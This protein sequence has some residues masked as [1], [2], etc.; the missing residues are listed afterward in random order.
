MTEIEDEEKIDPVEP[1]SDV[2]IDLGP[3]IDDDDGQ[4]DEYQLSSSPNDFNVLTITSFIESGAIKIPGFQR[5]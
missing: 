4:I 3:D 2:G 5:Q 1:G